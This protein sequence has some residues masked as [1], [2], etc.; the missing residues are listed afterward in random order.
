[1]RVCPLRRIEMKSLK[2]VIADDHAVVRTGLS[3]LLS[4]MEGIEVA[5]VARDGREAVDRV[6]DCRPDVAI[7]DLSMPQL[8][9]LGAIRELKRLVPNTAVLVLTMFDDDESVFEAMQA[10]ARGYVLKGAEQEEIERALRAVVAGEL[11]LGPGA[12]NRALAFFSSRPAQPGQQFPELTPRE[13]E[14]L[15]ALATGLSNSAIARRLGIATKTVANNISSIFSKLQV[16][17]RTQA[18]IRA[19]DAGLGRE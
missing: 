6:L 10:G 5:G 19:R 2:V 16:T 15:D 14:I 8:D 11:I 1:M 18:V 4:S 17:D 13:R 7:I 3:A 12:A 9:G